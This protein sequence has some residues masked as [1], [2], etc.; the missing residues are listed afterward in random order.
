VPNCAEGGVL[1][2]LPGIIGSLQAMEA[3]KL[4]LGEGESLVGRLLIF[5]ALEMRWREVALRRNPG[6]PVCGDE[7]TQT[8]LID[9]ERFCGVVEDG[10]AAEEDPGVPGITP[11]ELARRL[12]AADPPF[13]LDVREGWE[14]AAASLAPEGAHHIP[15]D[16]LEERRH[17]VPEDRPVVVYCRSGQRSLR[18]ARSLAAAGVP[19]VYNLEGGILA[20]A[21]DRAPGLP[22]V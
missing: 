21:R 7:P 6:C 9:Y 1:G 3:V 19:E 13:L 17:E 16:E 20:W 18:A 5:D 10:P 8:G 15:L 11:G 4:L 12:D 22:V 2:V 14:W